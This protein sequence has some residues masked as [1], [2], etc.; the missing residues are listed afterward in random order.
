MIVA[1]R[2]K[3]WL[4]RPVRWWRNRFLTDPTCRTIFRRC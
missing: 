4:L 2:F 1:S 3:H